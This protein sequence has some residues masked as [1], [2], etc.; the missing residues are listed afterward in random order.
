MK[1]RT[2]AALAAAA[3]ALGAGVALAAPASATEDNAV[4]CPGVTGWFVNPDETGSET[5]PDLRPEMTEAGAVMDGPG[6]IKRTLPP[7]SLADLKKATIET[8]ALTGSLPLVKY[9]ASVPGVAGT[10]STINLRPDGKV[11]SSK[12][13]SGPGSQDSPVDTFADLIGKSA[14]YTVDTRAFTVGAGYAY[15]T[16]NKVTIVSLTYDGT[17]HSLKCV[18]V[19]PSSPAATPTG[20]VVNPTPTATAPASP[21]VTP[22]GSAV[23]TLPKTGPK[24]GDIALFGGIGLLVGLIAV[25]GVVAYQ[26]RRRTTFTA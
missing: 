12:I 21:T 5:K 3:L 25:G 7:T 14:H 17:K 18:P 9:E 19:T 11:W 26:R 1:V 2:A 22:S 16:G 24:A 8:T 23:P 13:A 6:L 10:Y 4:G 20:G 15:D